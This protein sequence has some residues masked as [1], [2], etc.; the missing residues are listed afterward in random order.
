MS[1]IKSKQIDELKLAG[2]AANGEYLAWNSSASSY[3]P[4]PQPIGAQGA[5]GATGNPGTPGTPGAIG[6]QGTTGAQGLQGLTG[7]PGAIG[8]QGTTGA[9]GA[10]GLTGAVGAQGAQGAVGAQGITGTRGATGGYTIEYDNSTLN[11]I[12]EVPGDLAYTNPTF[13]INGGTLF[14]S[15]TDRHG[16]TIQAVGGA[17]VL[18]NI[19]ELGYDGSLGHRILI[20]EQGDRSKVNHYSYDFVLGDA[21]ISGQN[22]FIYFES[23]Q[24]EGGS[25]ETTF[26]DPCI[27]FNLVGAQGTDG[28]TGTPGTPGAS[29]L[30]GA[31][32]AQGAQ[33][34]AGPRGAQGNIGNTGSTGAQGAAG[35]GFNTVLNAGDNRILTALS[36]FIP[37]YQNQA[38]AESSLL[39]DGPAGTFNA[40]DIMTAD[41]KMQ[42]EF[43][44]SNSNNSIE[45][46]IFQTAAQNYPNPNNGGQLQGCLMIEPSLMVE[47]VLMQEPVPMVYDLAAPYGI[48]YQVSSLR[49][50]E[51]VK[52]LDVDTDLLFKE[53]RGVSYT[54]KGAKKVQ[55][56]F[57]AEE[58]E[59][60]DP[61]NVIHDEE[62]EPFS[63]DYGRMVPILFEVI[64]DLRTRI[65]LLEQK[66]K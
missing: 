52:T 54:G 17:T 61:N 35:T 5:Q 29:G 1:R 6:A 38:Q 48:G 26:I 64:R 20:F 33:G 42:E 34:A 16:N 19:Q 32:G 60:Y 9:Q 3:E 23:L 65:E 44:I 13:I 49:F 51:N 55:I 21:G 8:A 43:R 31:Q 36:P 45:A 12:T 63:L 41:W 30:S 2:G 57:I 50:K 56:G 22:T 39:F 40:N 25:G 11:A 62:G 18:D 10:Q 46:W 37:G 14:V 7:T 59:K 47:D 4:L 27:S 28:P 15:G 58:V 66:I 53:V 24:Y